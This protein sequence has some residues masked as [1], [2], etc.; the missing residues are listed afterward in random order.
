LFDYL[1][2]EMAGFTVN[3]SA[4]ILSEIHRIFQEISKQTLV[5]VYEEWITQLKR[6]T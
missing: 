1:K 3:S 2:S 5:A 4:D 6:I